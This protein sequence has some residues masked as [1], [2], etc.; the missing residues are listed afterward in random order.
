MTI[1]TM[2]GEVEWDEVLNIECA[3]YSS[4]PN[5]Q[6]PEASFYLVFERDMYILTLGSL[7][8]SK[9]QYLGD[10]SFL[11]STEMLGEAYVLALINLKKQEIGNLLRNKTPQNSRLDILYT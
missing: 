10:K 11:L 7:L 3:V 2:K 6:S 4:F 1:F 8:Q 5:S 9:L